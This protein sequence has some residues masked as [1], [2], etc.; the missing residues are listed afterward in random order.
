MLRYRPQR[1]ATVI[2]STRAGL[3]AHECVG[4]GGDIPVVGGLDAAAERGAGALLIGVAPQGGGLPPEWR[5]TV[6]DA[7]TRG[8]DVLSGLH[9][10]LGDDPELASIAAAHGARIVDARR[11]PA[12]R[13]VAA[14]R[15]ASVDSLVALTVG[16]DCNVGKMTT[17]LELARGF[18]A[19]GTSAAFVA[20]GQTGMF[21]ADHG[22]AVDA[23]PADFVAG[24]V[25]Q[26][27]LEAARAADV[28]V[29]EG[30]GALHHPAYSGVT[31][32]LLHGACPRAI[33]LCHQAG[34]E[35]VRAPFGATNDG[36]PRIEPL[37]VLVHAYEAAAEWVSTGR[38]VGV[39]L[40]TH[41]LSDAEARRAVDEASRETGLPATDPV[42]DGADVLVDA[43]ESVRAARGGSRATLG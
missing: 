27:V 36:E 30:Q 41:G 15:A 17:A 10:F 2:D 8:W 11:P 34:R 5:A 13:P 14:R 26:L 23:V 32:A 31:L 28:V 4:V 18:E 43:L 7:L 37:S 6:R 35:R 21:I 33:V 20:T 29:V 16:T 22:V 9:V 39:A 12:A 40:N 42:R 19:R 38:V 3:T 1:V 25:E 24:V